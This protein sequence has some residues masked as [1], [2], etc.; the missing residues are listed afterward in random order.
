MIVDLPGQ[1]QQKR[2][3]T[4]SLYG[5]YRYWASRATYFLRWNIKQV[6]AYGTNWKIEIFKTGKYS[7][8]VYKSKDFQ[9]WNN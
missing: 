2:R 1:A 9:S 8:Y 5:W 7:K 3:L 4:S 6:S